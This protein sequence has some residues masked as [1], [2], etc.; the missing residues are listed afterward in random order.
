MIYSGFMTDYTQLRKVTGDSAD[1]RYIA[2]GTEN[3]LSQYDAVMIDQ[4]EI[5]IA[6]DSAYRGAKPKHLD[7]LAEALRAGVSEALYVVDQAGED[8]NLRHF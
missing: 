4:P 6:V 1:Y 7:V 8:V 2:P 5:F 3:R